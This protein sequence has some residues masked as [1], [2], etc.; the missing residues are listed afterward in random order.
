MTCGCEW[1]GDAPELFDERCV[2]ARKEHRCCDCGTLIRPG[3]RYTL[4][5]G[6]WDGEFETFAICQSCDDLRSRCDLA[7]TSYGDLADGVYWRL[8]DNPQDMELLAF[9]RRRAAALDLVPK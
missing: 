5:S 8:E 2:R 9:E 3:E 4:V 7:C 6:K 1:D